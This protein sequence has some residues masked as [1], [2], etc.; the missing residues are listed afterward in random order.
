MVLVLCISMP[1]ALDSRLLFSISM[2]IIQTTE[3]TEYSV[4]FTE[5]NVE[6]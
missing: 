3:F 4:T 5:Y 2:N 6:K 1:Y